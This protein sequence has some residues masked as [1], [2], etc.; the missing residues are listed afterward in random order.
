MAEIEDEDLKRL[1]AHMKADF[2]PVQP[3]TGGADAEY[4]STHALE[5]MAYHLGQID[6]KF[7]RL[8]GLLETLNASRK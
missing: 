1:E 2:L 6:R 3:R 4:R 5:Y 7:D 8:I